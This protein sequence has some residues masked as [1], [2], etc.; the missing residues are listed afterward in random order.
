MIKVW[1]IEHSM[2]LDGYQ[3]QEATDSYEFDVPDMEYLYIENSII[4]ARTEEEQQTY[5]AN[6]A[7]KIPSAFA[8]ANIPDKTQWYNDRKALLE[9]MT[10]EQYAEL[11]VQEGI[12]AS[13]YA[14]ETVVGD[15]SAVITA[16]TNE[17][18]KGV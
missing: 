10:D 9:G 17:L 11:R 12:T 15:R 6:E 16:I 3:P 2:F 18:S 5:L 7:L 8:V 13:V 14:T 1:L 4:K